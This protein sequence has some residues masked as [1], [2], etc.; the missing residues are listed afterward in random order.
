MSSNPS[1]PPS[2]S[3]VPGERA[4]SA[5]SPAPGG[6]LFDPVLTRR[7]VQLS[8]PVMLA[9]LTQTL[10]NQ[11]DHV[12]V[13]HLPQSEATPGQAAVQIS[14]ILLWAFG[15]FLAAIAVGT[16]AL[17]ARRAGADDAEGAGAVS[18]NSMVL[19]VVSSIIVSAICWSLAPSMF[20]IAKD[21][22]VRE[23]GI[24]FLRWRFLQIGGMVIT[25]SL[26]AFFDGL[27]KTRVHMGVALV[28]NVANFL[29]CVG[30][31]FGDSAPGIPFIDS[32]H[33]LLLGIAGGHL[34]KMGVEGAGLAS[35]LSSYL[36]LLIMFAWSFRGEY[37]PYHLRRPGNLSLRTMRDI[38]RLSVP[39]GF[40]TLFAMAGFGFVIFVVG[41]LDAAA[42]R[43]DGR[44]IYSA[45]TSNIINVLQ[46]AF[47]SCLAYGTATATL[48]SQSLGARAAD[49]AERYTYTALRIGML[50]FL[51]VGLLMSI[52]AP[53]ILHFWNPDMQVVEVGAPILRVLGLICPII[54]AALVFTQ[55]LYGA[56][57]TVFVMI[58][59]LIL[60][61]VCLV[62]LSWVLGVTLGL[63]IWGVWS[64]L[65]FYICA[66]ALVMYLKFRTNTW[67]TIHI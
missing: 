43:A 53:Q 27:G 65:I 11:V 64:A 36:G 37:R 52:F 6:G 21:P 42:G 31:M 56:G 7:I 10:I 41:R 29:L 48:V 1:A 44:T 30:L 58:S 67:K 63:G 50:L 57:N 35:M 24:P 49:L 22:V 26:K 39:S 2:P 13:G 40:A 61:F 25:A 46:I 15:G 3:G 62:P 55:A 32:V 66:L 59:E 23:L 51:G 19:A 33:G 54:V 5:A 16:Q 38:A 45:A 60:H 34:P 17:T 4:P 8:Y 28:M 18:T 47:I 12:L 9:M 20:K 14:V